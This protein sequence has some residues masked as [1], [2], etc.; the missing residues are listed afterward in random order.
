MFEKRVSRCCFSGA[1]VSVI[2]SASSAISASS[3]RSASSASSSGS[4]VSKTPSEGRK[5]GSASGAG[6]FTGG[7]S[8]SDT[9]PSRPF[10]GPD[11]PFLPA[12][13]FSPMSL[14]HMRFAAPMKLTLRVGR[15]AGTSHRPSCPFTSPDPLFFFALSFAPLSLAHKRFTNGSFANGSFAPLS[16]AQ[17]SFVPMR[18]APSRFAPLRSAPPRFAPS[19]FALARFARFRSAFFRFAPSRFALKRFA[20]LRSALG[21]CG[22]TSGFLRR[23]SFHASTPFRRMARCSGFAIIKPLFESF[24]H[25]LLIMKTDRFRCQLPR[26]ICHFSPQFTETTLVVDGGDPLVEVG[27]FGFVAVSLPSSDFEDD[28]GAGFEFDEDVFR[29]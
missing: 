22:T 4:A 7:G 1:L 13:S 5:M 3:D 25:G 14:A 2:S 23:H 21:R 27:A 6:G 8:L 11:P 16:F 15:F 12:L 24:F 10:S 28:M 29:N 19:R 20:S 18:S 17:R 9:F 26:I